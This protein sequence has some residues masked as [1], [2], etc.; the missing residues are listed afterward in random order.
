MQ[1]ALRN[2]RVNKI[3]S[4]SKLEEI[5]QSGPMEKSCHISSANS[6]LDDSGRSESM[7]QKRIYRIDTLALESLPSPF[8]SPCA[9]REDYTSINEMESASVRY[10][11]NE[12]NG[13]ST[14]KEKPLG[15]L[16]DEKQLSSGTDMTDTDIESCGG[17]I[18]HTSINDP[19]YQPLTEPPEIR[20]SKDKGNDTS[21]RRSALESL[22]LSIGLTGVKRNSMCD[23]DQGDKFDLPAP[24][25]FEDSTIL[26]HTK[27]SDT[28]QKKKNKKS[29]HLQIQRSRSTK[30]YEDVDGT[31]RK[32][33]APTKAITLEH[34]FN[35]GPNG[36]LNDDVSVIVSL[37]NDLMSIIIDFFTYNTNLP[38]EHH[39]FLYSFHQIVQ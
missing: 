19:M 10:F 9:F 21:I 27:D 17:S 13:Y 36:H 33:K 28:I 4:L 24:P 38:T 16:R 26:V 23:D 34:L 1:L 6:T 30:Y 5:F 3:K 8:S 7:N 20:R 11:N 31:V 2:L 32:K 18:I 29:P 35:A 12:G 22:P 25:S 14:P 39:K 37:S 15:S